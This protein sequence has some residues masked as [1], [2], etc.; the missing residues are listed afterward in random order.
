MMMK[1]SSTNKNIHTGFRN[2]L[3]HKW[4]QLRSLLETK[5]VPPRLMFPLFESMKAMEETILSK[6][7]FLAGMPNS[8]KTSLLNRFIYSSFPLIPLQPKVDCPIEIQCSFE[9]NSFHCEFVFYSNEDIRPPLKEPFLSPCLGTIEVITGKFAE[10][11]N[12]FR[13][14]LA[15]YS[16]EKRQLLRTIRF[17]G[18][19]NNLPLFITFVD[20][21]HCNEDRFHEYMQP[22]MAHSREIWWTSTHDAVDNENHPDHERRLRFLERYDSSVVTTWLITQV[23]LR[24]PPTPKEYYLDRWSSS[25]SRPSIH[26]FPIDFVYPEDAEL[27]SDIYELRKEWNDFDQHHV[28][29][30]INSQVSLI[31]GL[32]KILS[33]GGSPFPPIPDSLPRLIGSEQI[34]TIQRWSK[35]SWEELVSNARTRLSIVQDGFCWKDLSED[36]A[37]VWRNHVRLF[38]KEVKCRWS[39]IFSMFPECKTYHNIDHQLEQASRTVMGDQ[40]GSRIRGW[41]HANHFS[42]SLPTDDVLQRL[43]RYLVD[44]VENDF[45]TGTLPEIMERC[46]R[47]VSRSWIILDKRRGEEEEEEEE[48]KTTRLRLPFRLLEDESRQ[49]IPSTKVGVTS[50]CER[51]MDREEFVYWKQQLQGCCPLCRTR[52][53]KDASFCFEEPSLA[54]SIAEWERKKDAKVI[55]IITP[56]RERK[57]KRE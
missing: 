56:E 8:G 41:L 35:L 4:E 46:E 57:R 28:S 42:T 23:P 1:P 29:T 47:I 48:Q 16:K 3:V 36:L 49:R 40:V 15:S 39:T 14:V 2:V 11:S 24:C 34:I 32:L 53:S 22:Y 10:L 26:L 20:V 17:R 7:V 18:P 38:W 9:V 30:K 50:C 6:V 5:E 45:L 13:Q 27:F 12:Q 25:S 51:M 43:L 54:A 55:T 44:H 21:T 37:I 33:N 52:K 19:F 31:Q